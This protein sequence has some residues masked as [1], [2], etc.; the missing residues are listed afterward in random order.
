MDEPGSDLASQKCFTLTQANSVGTETYENQPN[1]EI[2]LEQGTQRLDRAA[3]NGVP[4]G[5]WE[6]RYNQ[7]S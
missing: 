7:V 4:L 3:L 2:A 6:G 1:P 5:N